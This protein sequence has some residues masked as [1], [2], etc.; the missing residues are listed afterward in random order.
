MQRSIISALLALL[1]L[2]FGLVRAS[3]V[4]GASGDGPVAVAEHQARLT[5]VEG[6]SFCLICTLSVGFLAT[7]VAHTA[8][9][10]LTPC[11]R[12]VVLQD[13]EADIATVLTLFPRGPSASSQLS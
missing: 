11:D 12:R 3:R 1:I 5:P 9:S 10:S 4:H 13:E 7:P 6:G 8:E 2:G